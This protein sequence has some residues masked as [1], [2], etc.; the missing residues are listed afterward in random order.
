MAQP[1]EG[2]VPERDELA[3]AVEDGVVEPPAEEQRERPLALGRGRDRGAPA[4]DSLA[5][6]HRNDQ[7]EVVH[8]KAGPVRGVDVGGEGVEVDP[9][10]RGVGDERRL[11][12]SR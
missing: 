2:Q 10:Q 9:S 12:A 6:L 5:H 7:V 3:R 1:R 8:A 11:R 4:D